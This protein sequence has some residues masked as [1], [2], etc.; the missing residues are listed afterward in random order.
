MQNPDWPINL[1]LG[2]MPF[3]GA[4]VAGEDADGH[5]IMEAGF[6]ALSGTG[7]SIRSALDAVASR[8]PERAG[9]LGAYGELHAF[10]R[11]TAGGRGSG[12]LLAAMRSHARD[13]RALQLAR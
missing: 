8:R 13:R 1:I 12:P 3:F 7:G 10:A 5:A 6:R 2:G 9:A 11:D 4:S